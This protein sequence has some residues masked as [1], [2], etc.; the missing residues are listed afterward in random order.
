[1]VARVSVVSV[2]DAVADDL[3]ALVLRGEL[4]AGDGLT[5]SDVAARYD[6]ARPTAKAAIEKLVSE[7]LLR[8]TSHRT[9]RVV[10]LGVDDVRDIYRTR[11]FLERGA[12]R[13]LAENR[14]V[15]PEAV[16]A[17]REILLVGNTSSQD[18]VEPD[19]R[20]HMSLV[21]ALGSER[22]SRRYRGLVSE[23]KLC[24]S[25][26]QGQQ[27]LAAEVIAADH[28]DILDHI[29]AGDAD[30]AVGLLDDHLE[31]ASERLV[32]ALDDLSPAATAER[33]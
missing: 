14:S 25:Q 5:E 33:P 20:F 29:E 17:N 28:Q 19:M 12:I 18:I 21:D 32:G 23:V 15:P 26:L 11:G 22:T 7:S 6:V 3:R 30:K 8:R 16:R 2:V 27:L 10:A 31:R 24:M 9:A 1:M 4:T 13:R